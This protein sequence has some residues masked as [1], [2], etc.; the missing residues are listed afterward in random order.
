[1]YRNLRGLG[2][3]GSS[4]FRGA[5][6]PL[7]LRKLEVRKLE[8][9]NVSRMAALRS[10]VCRNLRGLE[11]PGTAR[12]LRTEYTR[13]V[14]LKNLGA[15]DARGLEARSDECFE[16]GGPHEFNLSYSRRSGGSWDRHILTD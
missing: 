8:V 5:N 16:D 6:T 4:R 13:W 12:F 14:R 7:E 2:A 10:S 1:M 9:T 11:A 15:P 3:P